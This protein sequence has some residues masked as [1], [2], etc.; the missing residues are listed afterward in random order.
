MSNT[1]GDV[2]YWLDNTLYLNITN[3]C[4]SDCYFCIRKFRKGLGGFALKL[5]KE[6]SIEQIIKALQEH[7]HRRIW[8]EV[9]FCG[10]GEPLT[11]LDTVLEVTRWIRKHTVLTV[12]LDTNGHGYMLNP[13][14]NVA[15]ELRKAGVKDVSVSLNAHDERIYEDVCKPRFKNAFQNVLGFICRTKNEGL[16]VEITAVTIPE[17]NIEKIREIAK[18]L[19]VKFRLRRYISCIW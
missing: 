16:N 11:R 12:R 10:F 18:S 7:V 9:V 6:P 3:K 15:E 2:V 1:D 14:R 8:K 13:K 17:I 19:G 4:S 5:Q